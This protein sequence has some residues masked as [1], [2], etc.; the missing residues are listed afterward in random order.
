MKR[1]STKLFAYFLFSL[2]IFS[3]D[4]LAQKKKPCASSLAKCP[5]QGCGTRFD[6]LLNRAKNRKT[7]P[8]TS[9]V[10]D[11]KLEEIKN[12][13]QPDTWTVNKNRNELKGEKREGQAVRVMAYLWKA[14]REHGE[15]CN[16]GLDAKGVPGELLTDIHMVLTENADDAEA[17]SVTAEITPRVRALRKNPVTWA[18]SRISPLKGKFIRVTGYLMLDTEHLIHNPLVRAT[19]WEVHPIAKLEVCTLTQEECEGGK[20][21]KNVP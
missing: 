9:S 4:A 21:W 17:I 8:A 11:M 13:E 19:N 15:S 10:V 14:K 18:A 1:L 3:S 6:A 16:C 5:T 7:I 20:G 12:M 2:L